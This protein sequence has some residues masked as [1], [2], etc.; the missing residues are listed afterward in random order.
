MTKLDRYANVCV[1]D[2]KDLKVRGIELDFDWSLFLI[3]EL[4]FYRR[5]HII[6]ISIVDKNVKNI[7]IDFLY[8]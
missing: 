3:I 6:Y 2:K 1:Y 7:L 5:H 4:L 8:Y